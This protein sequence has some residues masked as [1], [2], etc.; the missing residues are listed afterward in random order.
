MEPSTAAS[1]AAKVNPGDRFLLLDE[2]SGWY[3]I[4]YEQDQ[5]GWISSTYAEKEN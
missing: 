1:E 2:Q 3:Q 4:E 5:E